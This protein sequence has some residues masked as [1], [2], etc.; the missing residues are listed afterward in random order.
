MVATVTIIVAAALFI[1]GIALLALC[2][3]LTAFRIKN[4]KK[5][6]RIAIVGCFAGLSMV[7]IPL[8]GLMTVRHANGIKE[9]HYLEM[10]NTATIHYEVVNQSNREVFKYD[11]VKYAEVMPEFFDEEDYQVWCEPPESFFQLE[12]AVLNIKTKQSLLDLL[13]NA[14]QMMTLYKPPAGCE[15]SLLIGDYAFAPVDQIEKVE[16][17][18][19]DFDHYN[20]FEYERE[21]HD[22]D[23]IS[24]NLD[25]GILNKMRRIMKQR[26]NTQDEGCVYSISCTSSDKLF[27]GS[28]EMLNA[29]GTWYLRSGEVELNDE[30]EDTFIK[31]PDDFDNY[32]DAVFYAL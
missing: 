32:F 24:V 10:E 17:Y 27:V 5:I 12:N 3:G 30:I 9:D 4:K 13:F 26:H 7:L 28:F 14:K 16:E 20:I 8:F 22:E 31:L 11:G 6:S 18:Y 15:Y 23:N 21:D 19:E 1:L 2:F 25:S 29:H